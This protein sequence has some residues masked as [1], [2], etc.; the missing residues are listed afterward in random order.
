MK[1]WFYLCFHF[2]ANKFLLLLRKEEFYV[3]SISRRD[4]ELAIEG[5]WKK[6]WKVFF[7]LDKNENLDKNPLI[8]YSRLCDFPQAGKLRPGE[9]LDTKVRFVFAITQ[10]L[11][12]IMSCNFFYLILSLSFISN[13][14]YSQIL[15]EKNKFLSLCKKEKKNFT[16]TKKVFSYFVSIFFLP[17]KGNFFESQKN[18]NFFFLILL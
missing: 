11:P 18:L 6:L 3:F 1:F 7:F 12:K 9:V 17:L 4:F 16:R 14:S 5:L 8:V 13:W 15:I 10:S 2:I